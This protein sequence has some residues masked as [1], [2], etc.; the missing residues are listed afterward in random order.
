MFLRAAEAVSLE[1]SVCREMWSVAFLLLLDWQESGSLLASSGPLE[2][3][4]NVSFGQLYYSEDSL[5][6]EIF[7]DIRH[8]YIH[9]STGI[10][11]RLAGV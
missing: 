10:Y 5:N 2:L 9:P 7:F 3:L 11:F 8:M 4:L 6:L 1:F